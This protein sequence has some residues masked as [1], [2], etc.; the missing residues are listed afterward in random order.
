MSSGLRPSAAVAA[1]ELGLE[2][3]LFGQFA[4]PSDLGENTLGHRYQRIRLFEWTPV[5]GSG[6]RVVGVTASRYGEPVVQLLRRG[7]SG[8]RFY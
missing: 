5:G 4:L 3:L 1:A 8:Y 6:S 7:D 2:V